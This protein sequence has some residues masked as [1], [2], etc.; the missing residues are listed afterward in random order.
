ME[1]NLFRDKHKEFRHIDKSTFQD[2]IY[3]Y[4]GNLNIDSF[5]ILSGNIDISQRAEEAAEKGSIRF[6]EIDATIYKICNDTIY[7]TGKGYLELNATG[8]LMDKGRL[9]V[10]LKARIFDRVNTFTVNGGL[11]G[12]D[13][14]SLNRMLEK[15]AFITINSGIIN[16]MSF[17]FTANNT[18]A[19]GSLMVL[20]QGLNV[21]SINKKSGK[22]TGIIARVKSVVANIIMI[23][24]NPMPGDEVRQG[25]IEYERDPE[26][27]LFNYV[28]K[29][30]L[31]GINT[32]ITKTKAP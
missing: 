30:L 16:E 1:L 31:S 10:L 15:T 7:K 8:L 29:S 28:F 14:S 9:T 11:S 13:A 2:L 3:N 27:F 32:S 17:S 6:N 24:S 4:P 20:Y 25:I 22:S 18:K 12:M 26:R 23:E 21:A 5:R 19:T